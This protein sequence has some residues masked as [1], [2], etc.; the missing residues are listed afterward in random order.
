LKILF[1]ISCLFTIGYSHGQILK[2]D[3][4][5]S[6]EANERI[7]VALVDT[8]FQRGKEDYYNDSVDYETEFVKNLLFVLKLPNSF[9]YKFSSLAGLHSDYNPWRISIIYSDDSLFRIFNWLS[10]T[11]GT[12]YCFPAVF[13]A[14][15]K[16]K[17]IIN[18]Y[19]VFS[20]GDQ[21][22]T[23]YEAIYRIEQS[24]KQQYLCLGKG[25]ASGRLPF[26][27]IEAYEITEDSIVGSDIL[28]DSAHFSSAILV[29]RESTMYDSSAQNI[30]EIIYIKKKQLLKIP[31]ITG[32]GLLLDNV[33]WTG[34]LIQLKFNGSKFSKLEKEKP[35]K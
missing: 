26:A 11:S 33:R 7:L 34:R 32:D 18:S 13:Q 1:T 8:A 29:D 28:Q 9:Q 10:P 19:P 15:N 24:K 14:I 5:H 4:L 17:K 2:V 12:W 23:S 35:L 30:P 20:E 16:N 6:I 21:P 27:M 25:Q 3:S 31:E 22:S